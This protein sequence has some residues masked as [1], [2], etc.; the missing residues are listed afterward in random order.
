MASDH[1]A[2]QADSEFE[3]IK[4]VSFKPTNPLFT[5]YHTTLHNQD[6]QLLPV[7]AAAVADENADSVSYSN[8]DQDDDQ[9]EE[10]FESVV[11]TEEDEEEN[12]EA[13]RKDW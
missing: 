4:K 1:D 7:T 2:R 8:D 5:T 13:V 9:L 11:N 10:Q 12:E 3:P 6:G